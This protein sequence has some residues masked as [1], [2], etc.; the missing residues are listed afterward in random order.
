L[1][2]A[3]RSRTPE[4]ADVT[5]LVWHPAFLEHDTGAGHPER[6]ARLRAV[7]DRLRADGLLGDVAV[8]E[9]GEAALDAVAAVHDAAV[10]A[11]AKAVAERGGVL[12]G[13]DT[14]VSTG[15]WRAALLAAGGAVEA[16]DR[17]LDG[18]WRNAFV[19]CRPP[20]HHAERT[21]SM[22]FCLLNNVAV[23]AAHLRR[24]GVERVA[25]VDFDVHHG[26]GTQEIFETDPTVFYASVHQWP[27]YP[28]TGSARERGRGAGEGATL[29]CPLAAGTGD[30]E[31]VAAVE[32]AIVPAVDRFD[33]GF[34]LVSAGFDAHDRDPLSGTRVTETG[35]LRL[36]Q[37]LLDLARRR[38][39]G[40][41][42][43]CLEGGYDLDALAASVSAHVGALT[44]ASRS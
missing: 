13:G 30:L 14:V 29:N 33:P 12:D 3:R 42:V 18:T 15:S 44:G 35:F 39:G 10:P 4:N 16:A 22:G 8:H 9:P 20:G 7:L 17:V 26:N 19:L 28:G 25:I 1:S 6:P 32:E 31:W 27:W 38:S 34:V 23:A 5:G 21:A 36:T 2:P 11:R 24:R 37:A 41:L 40:R 43:A